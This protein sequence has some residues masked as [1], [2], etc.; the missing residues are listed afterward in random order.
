MDRWTDSQTPS[1]PPFPRHPSLDNRTLHVPQH[2]LPQRAPK[3]QVLPQNQMPPSE[4]FRVETVTSR[5]LGDREPLRM[6][7]PGGAVEVQDGARTAWGH[8]CPYLLACVLSSPRLCVPP[9]MGFGGV[10]TQAAQGTPRG[11]YPLDPWG[12][13]RPRRGGLHP[14]CFCLFSM[15][16]PR[17]RGGFPRDVPQ[18]GFPSP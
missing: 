1:R 10:P 12:P 3:C 14:A 9:W 5:F 15:P 16:V 2:I 18:P 17:A 13:H 6:P 7:R 8:P 4:W 11:W